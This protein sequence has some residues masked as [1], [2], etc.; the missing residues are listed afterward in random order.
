V[1]AVEA[2]APLNEPAGQFVQEAEPDA[3]A[4]VPAL[5]AVQLLAPLA[6]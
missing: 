6:D 3:G 4:I 1:Q 2:D 5:Q